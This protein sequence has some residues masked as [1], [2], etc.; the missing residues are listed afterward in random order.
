M[1]DGA[2]GDEMLEVCQEL[3]SDGNLTYFSFVLGSASTLGG[4][5]H[6]V[7]PMEMAADYAMPAIT[8]LT[9]AV[10]LPVIVTGRINHP[11]TAERILC[12]KETDLCGMT[13]AL[14]ADPDMPAK[15]ITGASD[16]FRV[17]IACN[18]ACTGHG[19][20]GFP[21]SCIQYP[22]SGRERS[23]GVKT[24]TDS[25]RRV[26][27]VGG[28]PAGLKAGAIAAER[29]HSVTL[30]EKT[31]RLGGQVLLAQLLPSRFEF[32]GLIDNLQRECLHAGVEIVTGTEVTPE[33]VAAEHPDALVISTGATPYVP[34]L[35]GADEA[36]VVTAWQVL[37]GEVNV[38]ASVVVAD[39]RCDWVGA[40]GAGTPPQRAH[41]R[42]SAGD[43]SEHKAVIIVDR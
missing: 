43:A 27:I 25:P 9:S 26:V 31:R 18:Q 32:G 1:P 14:I 15:A 5:T 4:S 6:I 41:V 11:Q 30:Y 20:S 7:P 28:G 35:P 13:R 17:C 23:L 34:D 40:G 33:L 38:G 21:I 24:R 29:G 37:T 42:K 3:E 16:K 19:L 22:E 8:K 36:H 39:W 10:S 12:A 2:T